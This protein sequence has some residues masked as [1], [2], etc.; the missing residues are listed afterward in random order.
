[1]VT[2]SGSR[3]GPGR[4][5]SCKGYEGLWL[6]PGTGAEVLVGGGLA[7]VVQGGGL[8]HVLVM[9]VSGYILLRGFLHGWRQ[10]VLAALYMITG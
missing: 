7:L 9:R 8:V 2:G 6:H 4:P 10:A 1:M 5:C 3:P